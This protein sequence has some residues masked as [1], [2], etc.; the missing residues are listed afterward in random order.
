MEVEIKVSV[1]R[2]LAAIAAG[3]GAVIAAEMKRLD[4]WAA[5]GR[6]QLHPQLVHFLE[7]RSYAKAQQFLGGASDIPLGVCGGRAGAAGRA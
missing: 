4:D 7:R 5:L 2:L 3:D 1:N 6:D